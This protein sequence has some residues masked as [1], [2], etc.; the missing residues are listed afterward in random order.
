M[1]F[2]LIT[3]CSS[4]CYTFAAAAAVLLSIFSRLVCYSSSLVEVLFLRNLF[5]FNKDILCA[6]VSKTALVY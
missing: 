2:E 4:V 3:L 5:V 1:V 6:S